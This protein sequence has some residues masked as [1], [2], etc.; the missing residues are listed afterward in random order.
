[1][2]TMSESPRTDRLGVSKVDHFFSLHGW[3]FREQYLHDYGIDGQVEIV[4]SNRPTG[5]LIALQI[6]SGESYFSESNEHGVIF[7]T[8]DAHI[9]YWFRH[10]L[11]VIVVLYDPVRDI[12]I[13]ESVNEETII[14]TGAG[15]KILVP[16]EKRLDESSLKELSEIT[17]PPEYIKKLNKLRLDKKWI[18]LLA[19]GESVYIEYEDWINKSL[20]RF[21]ITIGC[22][23]RDDVEEE[24]WPTLYGPGLSMEEAIERA[25]PWAD[26]E[27]DLDAHYD[28]MESVWYDEC[29]MGRDED[30]H[31]P[32]FSTPFSE[33]YERPEGIVPVSETGETE[34]YRLLLSLN[35]VGQAFYDLDEYLSENDDISDRTFTL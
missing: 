28:F 14:S 17:Q 26:Y 33:W 11:P 30:T 1:M 29:Y 9:D 15:W 7:R 2:V 5:D 21:S 32:Y 19:E 22:D 24:S 13:W 4:E 20:P 18:D 25:I 12:C 27:M 31:E 10:A 35:K 3:L 8:D 16:H 6:K 34:R 23:S